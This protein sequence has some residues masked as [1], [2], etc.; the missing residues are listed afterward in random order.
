MNKDQRQIIIAF[1]N[2][3]AGCLLAYL[4]LQSYYGTYLDLVLE[5]LA[6]FRFY[7]AI[8]LI[9]LGLFIKMGDKK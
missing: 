4:F 2:F 9:G 5:N 1:C 8:V 6:D 7:I 3:I